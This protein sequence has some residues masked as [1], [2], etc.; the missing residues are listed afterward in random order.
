MLPFRAEVDLGAMTIKVHSAFPKVPALVESHHQIYL[1]HPGHAL[2]ESYPSA[3]KRSKYSAAPASGAITF[4]SNLL[5][6]LHWL[7]WHQILLF[8]S[9]L[10]LVT[11]KAHLTLD[12]CI[13]GNNRFTYSFECIS[14]S[15]YLYRHIVCVYIYIYIYLVRYKM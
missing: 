1:C 7:I 11:L 12:V 4:L 2:G 10:Y 9:K 6:I 8:Y 15:M 13:W 14:I 5:I 3:E